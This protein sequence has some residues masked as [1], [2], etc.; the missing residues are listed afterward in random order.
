M[1]RLLLTS[2]LLAL[3]AVAGC[4]KNAE[5][6]SA[7]SE[8]V[9][10]AHD[11]AEAPGAPNINLAAAPGVAF[12]Y[13]YNFVLPD[14]TIADVQEAHAAACEKLGPSQCRITGMRYTL[15]DDDRISAE[16]SFKLAPELARAFG[17]EG[18][19]VV[20]KAAGKLVNAE[21][22]GEDVTPTIDNAK[23]ISSDVVTRLAA[24]ETKLKAGGLGDAARSE[25]ENQAALLRD[26][27]TL[28]KGSKTGAEALLAST[29]MTFEYNGDIGFSLGGNPVGN[30]V[31]SAWSSLATMIAFVLT[32]VGVTLPWILLIAL[33]IALSRSR[34][35]L[36][37]RR[38]VRGQPTPALVAGG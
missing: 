28:A 36:A 19:A 25:L 20:E 22:S 37:L 35:G 8:R 24:I 16:L 32:A 30:A 11:R 29:P 38:F 17:K 21:I 1:R 23:R 31:H 13:G 14:K 2:S 18:I 33:L 15:L 5:E 27:L 3:I 9:A 7:P 4:G 6:S 34:L 12:T 26:Q 10:A